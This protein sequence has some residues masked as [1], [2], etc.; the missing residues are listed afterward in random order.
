MAKKYY[1][2]KVITRINTDVVE[3]DPDIDCL[4][5]EVDPQNPEELTAIKVRIEKWDGYSF[6]Y[7]RVSVT[8]YISEITAEEAKNYTIFK[9]A[10]YFPELAKES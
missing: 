2:D 3:S 9:A 1:L 10:D 7:N 8:T 5:Y 6:N 4:V